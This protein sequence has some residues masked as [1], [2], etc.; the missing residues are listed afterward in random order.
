MNTV[1]VPN[2]LSGLRLLLAPVLAIVAWLGHPVLFLVCLTV[3]LASDA[4]D[5]WLARRLGQ[6][7]E[8]GTKLDSWA[9]F[10]LCLC[11]PLGSWWLWPD[12]VRREAIFVGV[13]ILGYTVPGMFGLLKYHRLPSYHTRIAKLAAV[14]MG[15]SVL[16]LLNGGAAWP[17]RV[18][19]LV[20]LMAALE[21]IAITAVLPHWTS[22]VASLMQAI[23]IFRNQ[24]HP[25]GQSESGPLTSTAQPNTRL[26]PTA[27]GTRTIR[28]G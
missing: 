20:V 7:S 9:D 22:N 19:T 6:T 11:V 1:T 16:I 3:A 5:G 18:S 28:R 17:F 4:I 14:L 27:V 10:A 12:V 26:Q 25:S 24:Q 15:F 23:E 13:A 2:L 21:E 8:L